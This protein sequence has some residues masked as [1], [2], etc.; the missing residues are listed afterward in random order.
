MDRYR[1][2]TRHRS[3]PE[4]DHKDQRE[5][6][7]GNGARELQHAADDETQPWRRRGIFSGKE[8]KREGKDSSEQGS[9]IADQN[10]LAEHPKPFAPAPEP[11][12]DVGPDP[13]AILQSED[14]IE[15][16]REVSK[17]GEERP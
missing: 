14:A 6:N 9:D 1:Q 17:I 8:V 13:R 5:H 7:A 3:E 16:A 4:C 15:I 10:G 12:A 2:H 11:L